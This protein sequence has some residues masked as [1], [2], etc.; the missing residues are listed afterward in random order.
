MI[1]HEG[2]YTRVE[3]E[4]LSETCPRIKDEGEKRTKER[5][6]PGREYEE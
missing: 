6:S 3:G 1:I 2:L 5:W 4:T